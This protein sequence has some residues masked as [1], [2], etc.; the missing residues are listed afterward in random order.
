[1]EPPTVPPADDPP[2]ED[3]PTGILARIDARK[4]EIERA[5]QVA[6][7]AA[8][9]QL[10]EA[11]AQAERILGARHEQAAREAAAAGARIVAEAGRSAEEIAAAGAREATAVRTTSR[12]RIG[13]A[14]EALLAVVLPALPGEG[15]GR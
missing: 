3:S 2:P 5:M 14:A 11:R 15:A 9:A 7:E 13:Q 10:A 1:M 12:E 8:A 4:R 6:R